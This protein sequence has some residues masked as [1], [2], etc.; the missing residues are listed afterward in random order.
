MATTRDTNG[1]G[2]AVTRIGGIAG[3]VGSSVEQGAGWLWSQTQE[4]AGR[5]VGQVQDVATWT[6]GEVESGASWT[7]TEL[8][9]H[10]YLGGLLAGAAGIAAASA[11]GVGELAAGIAIGYAAYLVLAEGESPM[12]ALGDAISWEHGKLKRETRTSSNK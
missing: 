1:M 8:K 4:V 9:A 12:Q 5:A 7:Q 6:A 11:I 3:S 2:A 10:P